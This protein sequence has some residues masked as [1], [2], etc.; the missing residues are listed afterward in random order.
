MPTKGAVPWRREEHTGAKH[1][2]YDS[3]LR[4]WFPILLGGSHHFRSAT[5]IEGFSGPGIY[6]DGEEGSPIIA[7]RALLETPKLLAGLPTPV[8]FVFVDD[9]PRCTRLLRDRVEA[10]F[11]E[12]PQD[13]MS[14]HVEEGRCGERLETALD[15]IQAWGYP[16]FA[17]L[18]SWGNV[19]V[20]HRLL[21]RLA[22]NKAS[23][24]IV[25]LAPQHFVRFV[26]QIEG[27]GDEVFGGDQEWRKLAELPDGAAK[28][29]HLLT[30]YRRALQ[31]AG[32]GFL[33]D[34]ELVTPKGESLYLVFGTNHRRGVEKMKDVLWT[35]DPETGIGFRDPRDVNQSS[36]F[37]DEVRVY[38]LMN[39]L[40]DQL[41][42][43]GPSKVYKLA[44]HALFDTVFKFNHALPAVRL[45]CDAGRVETDDGKPVTYNSVVRLAGHH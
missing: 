16:I 1:R 26:S 2:V 20:P 36:L 12:Y 32:F 17:V 45:L 37:G 7:I 39:L 27:S 24:V 38:P 40:E 8:R 34:F 42:E 9:D 15:Q 11:P 28:R 31:R 10:S 13:R 5:Y 3:Y 33:L 18:D 44:N 43:V 35:V 25:T 30:C 4:M 19:P 29:R 23:E 14:V 22:A 41:R 21:A 6:R